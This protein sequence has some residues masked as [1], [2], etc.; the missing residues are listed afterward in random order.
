MSMFQ[1]KIA[2]WRMTHHSFFTVTGGHWQALKSGLYAC[3]RLLLSPISPLFSF[4]LPEC[5]P[6]LPVC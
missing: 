4:S 1:Q 2:M 3:V 5:L 6:I